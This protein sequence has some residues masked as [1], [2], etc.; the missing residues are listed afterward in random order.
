MKAIC[1]VCKREIEVEEETRTWPYHDRMPPLRWQL[2][3][4]SKQGLEAQPP[5]AQFEDVYALYAFVAKDTTGQ[6]GIVAAPINGQIM[7]LV[8]AD[9]ERIQS[10]MPY[11]QLAANARGCDITLALFS[12][13][14]DVE[15]I[16]PSYT[17]PAKEER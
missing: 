11:A 7:P 10:L 17:R 1:P 4:A 6:E 13:R 8:G 16:H 3:P 14:T 2:C 15:T 9:L 5:L 12:G